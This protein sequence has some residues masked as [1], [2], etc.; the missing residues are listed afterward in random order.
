MSDFAKPYIK[1][2]FNKNA[3]PGGRRNPR[4][5]KMRKQATNLLPRFGVWMGWIRVLEAGER[6]GNYT[7]E[8]RRQQKYK[9]FL[10]KSKVEANRF[11]IVIS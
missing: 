4:K 7:P 2:P 10:C 8:D 9:T 11:L 3:M 5:R 1:R 6:F